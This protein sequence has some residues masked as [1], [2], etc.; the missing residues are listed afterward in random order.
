MLA[1]AEGAARGAL[2][3]LINERAS[4]EAGIRHPK[5]G[6]PAVTSGARREGEGLGSRMV[7]GPGQKR[8][9]RGW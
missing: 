5:V 1:F 3:S 2:A 8:V 6:R 9:M 7:R 4:A